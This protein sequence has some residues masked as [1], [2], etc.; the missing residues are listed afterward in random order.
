[1]ARSYSPTTAAES[2]GAGAISPSYCASSH[3]GT[4]ELGR[5][6]MSDAENEDE[7][8][9]EMESKVCFAAEVRSL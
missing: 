4:Y 6:E 7:D 8:E 5:Y 3:G 2:A 9:E 1:M